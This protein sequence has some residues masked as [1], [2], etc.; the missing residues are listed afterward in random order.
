M[1]KTFDF[2]SI[3]RASLEVVLGDDDRTVLHVT[4]PPERLIE[5]LI[6]SAESLEALRS[7]KNIEQVRAV[8]GL[9]ADIISC[10]LEGIKVTAE[11][12]RDK[13]NVKPLGLLLFVSSYMDFIK[14]FNDAKN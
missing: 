2:N 6:A 8:Y 10:N 13:Y 4:T 11:D 14:E 12:L 3:D 7:A 9:C 1:A 5:Q